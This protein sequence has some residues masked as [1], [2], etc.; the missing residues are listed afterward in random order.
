MV[1]HELKFWAG[2]VK[3][4]RFLDGW[5]GNKPT[6][7]LHKEVEEFIQEYATTHGKTMAL[8]VG[9]GVVSILNGVHSDVDVV[10]T[11]LLGEFYEVIFDYEQVK[12][13]PPIAVGGEQLSTI[14]LPEE[15][16]DVVH[17][18]NALDHCQD[19]KE[20][21]WQM[22]ACCKRGGYVII[23]G[24][25]NEGEAERYQGFHQ[26]NI[27]LPDT[28][29]YVQGHEDEYYL[30]APK[31]TPYLYLTKEIQNGKRWY[32]WIANKL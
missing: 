20:V 26:W 1:A 4:E 8:D 9:S 12:L 27:T 30:V 16:Y 6:P 13:N 23:Q 5:C 14:L 3:T 25:E 15:R 19:P 21:L 32:I 10:A 7:E 29:L 24:F 18:S 28:E 31:L 22:A 17:C 11:D 2:F